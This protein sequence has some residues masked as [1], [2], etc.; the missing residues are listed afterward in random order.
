MVFS[1]SMR[2][3]HHNQAQKQT[4]GQNPG[5]KQAP[6]QNQAQIQTPGHNQA[7]IQTPGQNQA[8]I[9]TPGQN[10]DQ[11][12]AQNH[13]QDQTLGQNQD[14]TLGQNQDQVGAENGGQALT[15][16]CVSG[17]E[18]SLERERH[19]QTLFLLLTYYRRRWRELQSQS[20]EAGTDTPT[21]AAKPELLL[22]NRYG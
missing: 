18:R 19:P 20:E 5:Q 10:Q 1:S 21:A 15:E 17:L 4:P 6:D 11:T 7:Q 22:T 16:A 3:H 8:Q 12:L 2:L 9:R 14:Q 13:A